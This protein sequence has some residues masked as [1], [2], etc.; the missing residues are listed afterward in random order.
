MIAA[1]KDKWYNCEMLRM[2]WL[3]AFD[4]LLFVKGCQSTNIPPWSQHHLPRPEVGECAGVGPAPLSRC[5]SRCSSACQ[6]CRLWHQPH[7]PAYRDQ[8]LRRHSCLY[9]SWNSSTCW[10]R[11]L[12]RKGDAVTVKWSEWL[13]V[14]DF[15][16][17]FYEVNVEGIR[18]PTFDLPKWWDFELKMI[19]LKTFHLVNVWSIWA[20]YR[21]V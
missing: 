10:K 20:A 11:H 9:C 12:H 4:S 2:K 3:L 6:D 1:R 8:R 13:I 14:I 16:Q 17:Y 21:S 7:C 19:V 15:A 5:Q 18:E